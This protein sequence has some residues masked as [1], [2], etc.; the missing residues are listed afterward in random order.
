MFGFLTNAL[1]LLLELF[2]ILVGQFFQIDQFIPS[3]FDGANDLVEFQMDCLR[4]AVLRVLD[5]KN[6]EEGDDGR[7]GIDDK[8]PGVRIMEGR[9]GYA[10][11]DDDED[12][13]G[14]SPGA[15]Q[16]R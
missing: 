16:D 14:E 15:A 11:D 4:V 6:H 3:A 8:L 9:A 12:G 1:K 5:E 2:E 7:A 10:P 13:R